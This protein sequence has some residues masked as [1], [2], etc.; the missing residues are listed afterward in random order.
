MQKEFHVHMLYAHTH[1]LIHTHTHTHT[2]IYT[3]IVIHTYTLTHSY[4]HSYTHTHTYLYA[5]TLIHT[6]S[7]THTYVHT[8][9]VMLRPCWCE[10]N[11]VIFQHN[12]GSPT[13]KGKHLLAAANAAEADA[14]KGQRKLKRVSFSLPPEATPL[15]VSQ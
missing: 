9:G 7:Y 5:Q 11:H 8:L 3:H 1:A 15:H 14:S 13:L 6:H 4:T 10:E 12:L 2:F